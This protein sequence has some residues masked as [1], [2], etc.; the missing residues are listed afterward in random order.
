MTPLEQIKE[1]L[2]LM[3]T[4]LVA[5][6]KSLGDS[7]SCNASNRRKNMLKKRVYNQAISDIQ[8]ILP[9]IIQEVEDS[10]R[11]LVCG[12]IYH[13]MELVDYDSTVEAFYEL[14]KRLKPT[15]LKEESK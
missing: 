13:W 5:Y 14:K 7:Q 10:T 3:K 1:R 4:D 2:E 11:K 9:S 12:E 8:A 15:S 6:S